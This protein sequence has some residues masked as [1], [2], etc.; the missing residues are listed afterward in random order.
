MCTASR[1]F[2]LTGAAKKTMVLLYFTTNMATKL[3]RTIYVSPTG[4]KG[5]ILL[6]LVQGSEL[7]TS[8]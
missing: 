4:T 2:K 7:H 8:S 3:C 6:L 1:T 5:H